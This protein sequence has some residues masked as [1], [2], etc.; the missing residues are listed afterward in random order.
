[1]KLPPHTTAEPG[2]IE[3]IRARHGLPGDGF[4]ALPDIGTIN[5][6]YR[7]GG[8]HVLRVPR[9]HPAHIAQTRADIIAAPA[10]RAAGVRTPRVA[11]MGRF[12]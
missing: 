11:G 7:I 2:A 4:E 1:M 9:N 8:E 10:A 12:V 6:I 3:A 5:A